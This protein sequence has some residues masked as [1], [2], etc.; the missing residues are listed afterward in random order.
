MNPWLTG[1]E[2]RPAN[3]TLGEAVSWLRAEPFGCACQGG[4]RCC[5]LVNRQAEALHRGAHITARLMADA[6]AAEDSSS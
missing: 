6:L 3:L 2:F 4:P 1:Q 5:L